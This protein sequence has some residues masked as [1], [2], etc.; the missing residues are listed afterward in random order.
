MMLG[1]ALV[2]MPG[3]LSKH[4]LSAFLEVAKACVI[5]E[6]LFIFVLIYGKS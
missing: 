2:S 3:L 6:G 4:F 1:V 5:A